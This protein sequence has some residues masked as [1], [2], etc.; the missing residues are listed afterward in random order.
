MLLLL[1]NYNTKQTRHS[2]LKPALE[3]AIA[4][5]PKPWL[6][7]RLGAFLWATTDCC[8][9]PTA[10]HPISSTHDLLKFKDTLPVEERSRLEARIPQWHEAL[11]VEAQEAAGVAALASFSPDPVWR[12][13]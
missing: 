6:L 4:A 2:Y 11:L 9:I 3:R 7:A 5:I 12:G 8:N 10:S 13:E 1:V